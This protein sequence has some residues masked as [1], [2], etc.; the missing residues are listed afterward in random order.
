[1]SQRTSNISS[2]QTHEPVC[3]CTA[4]TTF[5]SRSSL[6]ANE[7]ARKYLAACQF[8]V[9]N[10][11]N[12][13]LLEFAHNLNICFIFFSCLLFFQATFAQYCLCNI[14]RIAYPNTTFYNDLNLCVHFVVFFLRVLTF[15]QPFQYFRPYKKKHYN[16]N[17]N[18][19]DA[20][21]TLHF[22]YKAVFQNVFIQKIEE[23]KR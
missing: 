3:C 13:R 21:V 23:K 22:K 10:N 20:L 18:H 4:M 12:V 14:H 6:R 9:K 7:R 1:M 5:F 2:K 8:Q 19:T 17:K 11:R 16:N 15:W